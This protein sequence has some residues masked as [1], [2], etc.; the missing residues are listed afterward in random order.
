[1]ERVVI[2]FIPPIVGVNG[3][4]N[5]FRMGRRYASL[6]EGEEVFLRPRNRPRCV[7]W[8][9]VS[10]VRGLRQRE[11]YG[12]RQD[13]RR[14]GRAAVSN[15]LP[16]LWPAHRLAEQDGNGRETSQGQG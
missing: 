15:P 10:T 2:G 3:D 6:T 5:T 4:F 11:R 14:I 9:A 8:T 1:M 13:G 16:H 12:A 7:G